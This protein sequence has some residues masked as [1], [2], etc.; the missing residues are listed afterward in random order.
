[1]TS[2]IR[3]TPVPTKSVPPGFFTGGQDRRVEKGRM[4]TALPYTPWLVGR[5]FATPPQEPQPPLSGGGILGE[6]QQTPS[7]PAREYVG[8]L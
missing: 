1:M 8:A 5:E 3:R 6:G 7:P 4:L 2:E